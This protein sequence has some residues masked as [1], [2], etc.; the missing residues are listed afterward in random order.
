MRLW[1]RFYAALFPDDGAPGQWWGHDYNQCVPLLARV[2]LAMTKREGV[3]I[4]VVES[5]GAPGEVIEASLQGLLHDYE[6][7]GEISPLIQP[8]AEHR[9][10]L[11]AADS[12][13]RVVEHDR[14][15]RR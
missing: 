9:R 5:D 6:E 10:D 15:R 12:L 8:F 2:F 13:V 14:G 11:S 1:W 4:P 3:T 7:S